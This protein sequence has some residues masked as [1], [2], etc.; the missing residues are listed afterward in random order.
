MAQDSIQNLI[1]LN[2]AIECWEGV[3]R[4]SKMNTLLCALFLKDPCSTPCQDIP[5]R[6]F[7]YDFVELSYLNP[8]NQHY[9]DPRETLKKSHRSFAK[10][11]RFQFAY[12]WDQDDAVIIVLL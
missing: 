11:G 2:L 12:A 4:V 10:L 8:L 9:F 3:G 7:T 6:C 5:L 1:I